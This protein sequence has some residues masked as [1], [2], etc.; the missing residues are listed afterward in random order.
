MF[1]N[2]SKYLCDKADFTAAQ[3]EQVKAVCRERKINKHEFLLQE[4][5]I[6]TCN[7]FVCSGLMRAF[8]IDDFGNEHTT[9]FAPENYWTG[10]RV[11]VLSGKPSLINVD[12]IE[13]THL[14]VI[15]QKDFYL[16]NKNIE[17][18]NTVLSGVIQKNIVVSQ[19][20]M[21]GS[22]SQSA[23]EKYFNFLKKYG[24]ILNR[25]P[26]AMIASY[27]DITPQILTLIQQ[28]HHK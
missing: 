14:I 20:L 25:L 7:T 22:M 15:E 6:F 26:H 1:E 24:S 21:F 2:F 17:P 8:I 3:L 11:S 16:L 13:D 18:F 10:D 5:T 9:N 12:A 28:K 27:L 23:E 19:E 4:G